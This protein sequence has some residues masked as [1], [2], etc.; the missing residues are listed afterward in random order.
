ME[1]LM[2]G[3]GLRGAFR[4]RCSV[5]AMSVLL[6]G[7]LAAAGQDAE[8]LFDARRKGKIEFEAVSMFGYEKIEITVKNLTAA[9]VRLNPA[10]SVLMPPDAALQRLGLGGVVGGVPGED[11]SLIIIGPNGVWTGEI[12]SVCLDCAKGTPPNG[13][14]Y[15]LSS[16]PAEEE[17]LKV[18][19][20]W[21]ENPKISQSAVNDIIWAGRKLDTLKSQVL[22]QWLL[23]GRIIPS[24]GKLYFLSGLKAVFQVSDDFALWTKIGE[25]LDRVIAGGG[26][27]SGYIENIPGL[28]WYNLSERR[29]EYFFL[30]AAPK[31]VLL[32]PDRTIF[33]LCGGKLLRWAPGQKDF[34]LFMPAEIA[35]AAIG[36]SPVSPVLCVLTSD[37]GRVL[38][39]DR[40]G[41]TWTE[42]AGRGFC[43]VGA[44]DKSV[45]ACSTGG[46]LFRFQGQWRKI[47]PA[48]DDF[49]AGKRSCFVVEKRRVLVDE[50]SD[51]FVATATLPGNLISYCVDG[52]ADS[53]LAID[54][55]ARVLKLSSSGAWEVI[56]SVPDLGSGK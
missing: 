5:A 24:G 32:G 40:A 28:R 49:E 50:A 1:N 21:S 15:S 33:A 48:S 51:S 26:Q 38:Q 46:A 34:T 6:A 43:R 52:P 16:S 30:P 55:Q 47:H 27:V 42:L 13:I 12:H 7:P 11:S 45:Y 9:T 29:W 2:D 10:G 17:V 35:D 44:S 20:Y 23:G 41:E 53:M 18:L 37:A 14:K 25:N 4:I 22:P 36:P 31:K 3:G 19:K 8:N 39:F 56:C 54:E